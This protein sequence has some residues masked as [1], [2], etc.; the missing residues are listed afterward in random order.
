[1]TKIKQSSDFQSSGQ[2]NFYYLFELRMYITDNISKK[3]FLN[4][5]LE[6]HKTS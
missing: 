4:S 2:K 3:L 6:I 1:M 5:R